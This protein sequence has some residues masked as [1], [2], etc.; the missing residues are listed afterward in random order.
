MKMHE[1]GIKPFPSVTEVEER[2]AS[3][4]EHTI[5][6]IAQ[7]SPSFQVTSY[8]LQVDEAIAQTPLRD[9]ALVQLVLEKIPTKEL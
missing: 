4:K 8:M 9:L 6:T 3:S 5:Q 2:T 7:A 1:M